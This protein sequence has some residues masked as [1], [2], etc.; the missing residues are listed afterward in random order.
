MFSSNED[1]RF[2]VFK[3]TNNVVT[4]CPVCVWISILRGRL[5]C[6]GSWKISISIFSRSCCIVASW[7][8][9]C[10]CG[11]TNWTCVGRCIIGSCRICCLILIFVLYICWGRWRVRGSLASTS[12]SW[13]IPRMSTSL[14]LVHL[15]VWANRFLLILFVGST[16]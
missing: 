2:C 16:H 8:I 12:D 7:P 6:L 1:K 9:C 3:L 15:W 14:G 11:F 4:D 5:C 10:C 13:W